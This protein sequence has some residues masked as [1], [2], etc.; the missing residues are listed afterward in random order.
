MK[1]YSWFRCNDCGKPY[2]VLTSTLSKET[3]EALACSCGSKRRSSITRSEYDKL[4]HPKKSLLKEGEKHFTPPSTVR[5]RHHTPSIRTTLD[6]KRY[7]FSETE[8]HEKPRQKRETDMAKEKHGKGHDRPKKKRKRVLDVEESTGVTLMDEGVYRGRLEEIRDIETEW[9][10]SLRWIFALP[11]EEE[12]PLVSGIT[13]RKMSERSKAFKWS[14]ALLGEPLEV[15][16]EVD[17]DELTGLEADVVLKTGE[18]RDGTEVS[19]VVDVLPLKR[20]KKEKPEKKKPK[21]KHREAEEEEEEEEAE[22]EGEEEE[23]EEEEEF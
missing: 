19:N 1:G 20:K 23:G 4:S 3:L 16:D 6:G 2:R 17:L 11:E 14:G 12:E 21:K 8:K 10:D 22:E 13:S 18:L 7:D 15:G 9:G 5:K